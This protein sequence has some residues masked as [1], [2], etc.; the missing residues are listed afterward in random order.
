MPSPQKDGTCSRS[1]LLYASGEKVISS[2]A[3]RNVF[4]F[5]INAPGNP[6]DWKCK[7]RKG[8]SL[9]RPIWNRLLLRIE[10]TFRASAAGGVLCAT[11]LSGTDYRRGHGSEDSRVCVTLGTLTSARNVS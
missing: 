6:L 7:M 10:R 3:A 4:R 1:S 8:K 11:R 9:R 2:P 5:W